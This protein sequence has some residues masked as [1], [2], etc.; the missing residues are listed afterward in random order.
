MERADYNLRRSR[1]QDADPDGQCQ[2]DHQRIYP[3]PECD[4][5]D[6]DEQPLQDERESPCDRNGDSPGFEARG[7]MTGFEE[8]LQSQLFSKF[9]QPERLTPTHGTK[10]RAAAV[11]FFRAYSA[12]ITF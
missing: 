9:P 4:I 8:F 3:G 12:P 5:G 10:P 2:R 6:P 1:G 11:S 7:S